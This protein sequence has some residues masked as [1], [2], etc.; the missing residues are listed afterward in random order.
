VNENECTTEVVSGIKTTH[1][2]WN[3]YHDSFAVR[4][5]QGVV[6]YDCDKII[7]PW[8]NRRHITILTPHK[9]EPI[10]PRVDSDKRNSSLRYIEPIRFTRVTLNQ[11][12]YFVLA[13]ESETQKNIIIGSKKTAVSAPAPLIDAAKFNQVSM[14]HSSLWT[15]PNINAREQYETNVVYKIA[16]LIKDFDTIDAPYLTGVTNEKYENKKLNQAVQNIDEKVARVEEKQRA[17]LK[18]ADELDHHHQDSMEISLE[19]EQIDKQQND[20]LTDRP[21][22]LKDEIVL[23]DGD[24]KVYE[25][26]DKKRV[27][28][29]DLKRLPEVDVDVEYSLAE[30][31]TERPR[32]KLKLELNTEHG[33]VPNV[34]DEAT[35]EL[36]VYGRIIAQNRINVS[37]DPGIDQKI[38]EKYEQEYIYYASEFINSINAS[39]SIEPLKDHE[40]TD[41]LFVNSNIKKKFE[42]LPVPHNRTMKIG[43]SSFIKWEIYPE[44]KDPRNITQISPHYLIEMTKLTYPV[45]NKV[46]K[47][48]TWYAPGRDAKS[49]NTMIK[50]RWLRLKG[51]KMIATDFS[52]FDGTISAFWRTLLEKAIYK[53]FY[54]N[55]AQLIDELWSL[56][57][58]A[59]SYMKGK[60][61]RFIFYTNGERISG[62]PITTDGN[63]EV[64]AGSFYVALRMARLSRKEALYCLRESI[65]YGDDALLVIPENLEIEKLMNIYT[66]MGFNL[67]V[68]QCID[69]CIPFLSRTFVYDPESRLMASYPDTTKFLNRL[70]IIDERSEVPWQQQIFDKLIGYYLA[71]P[72]NEVVYNVYDTIGYYL[73]S[74]GLVEFSMKSV[75]HETLMKI[76][77][78]A[79]PS[80]AYAIINNKNEL[81]NANVTIDTIIKNLH[82]GIPPFA[83]A[84]GDQ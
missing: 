13:V 49:I 71:D 69:D 45:K 35:A 39:E 81:M 11:E 79:W 54:P 43:A 29:S 82:D 73:L 18:E 59:K 26:D 4:G 33:V 30:V 23:E 68:Q 78:G 41:T 63:T 70:G 56:D 37:T 72:H 46:L 2:F 7:T 47:K 75:T 16:P 8:D 31:D 77:T 3:Y 80:T 28:H 61:W 66:M 67:T 50:Q 57:F 83:A 51:Y 19:D 74:N 5:F 22:P 42:N 38:L 12:D 14:Y 64:N 24:L 36:G 6:S 52:R 34:K 20:F 53:K 48:N 9:V 27:Y 76:A 17:N 1:G 44:Q 55:D 58:N 60:D 15:K 21:L 65:C 84:N 62:T 32:S 10:E 25:L 40:L